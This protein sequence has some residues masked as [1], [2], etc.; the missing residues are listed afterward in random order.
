MACYKKTIAAIKIII[1]KK[2]QDTILVN[3]L[4]NPSKIIKEPYIYVQEIASY[5]K[6]R[7]LTIKNI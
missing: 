2:F 6:L 4:E 3:A 1:I 5:M 7:Q